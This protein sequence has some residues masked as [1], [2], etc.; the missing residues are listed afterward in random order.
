MID[1]CLTDLLER[2]ADHVR[3][4]SPAYFADVQEG[5]HP[6]V[7]S[8]C[9]SDS[10]V[11]QEAMFDVSHPGELFTPSNIGNQVRDRVCLDGDCRTVVDGSL[12]YPLVHTGTR[13]VAVVG[14]T[15]CG[16]VTAAHDHATDGGSEPAGIRKYV[17][18]LVP[19]VED[20]L[21]AGV[22][23]ATGDRAARIDGL[24]EYN[25]DRQVAFLD[26]SDE[27]PA[28]TALYGLVYD[29][30]GRYGGPAGRA[31]LVNVGGDRDTGRLRER[32]GASVRDHV[33][34]LTGY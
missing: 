24:V 18:M 29:I 32:V 7:V 23:D 6:P 1:E 27:I 19:V 3:G 5:Q 10:R 14:H 20:A 30:H 33:A 28:D 4:L 16:A 12:L 11:S 9:C 21:D 15:G 31:Y 13:A 8:V 34:R 17:E 22:V 25:V 2:N 26:E